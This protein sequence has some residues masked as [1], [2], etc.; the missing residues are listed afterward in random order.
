[1]IIWGSLLI[2][3][4]L[5]LIALYFFHKRI[6]WWEIIL[7]IGI[8][9]GIIL[10]IQAWY[11][12]SA[13]Q[14]PEYWGAYVEAVRYYEP[15]HEY[16]HQTC[17]ETYVCGSDS[18]GNPEY[19]TRTYDCSYHDFHPEY[20]VAI[21]NYGDEQTISKSE[22]DRLV[23]QFAIP[24]LNFV[25]LG[26][27]RWNDIDHCG[28][29]YDGD[30]Y[31]GN[32]NGD[33]NR[34]QPL[35]LKRDYTNKVIHSRTVFN[36]PVVSDTLPFLFSKLPTVPDQSRSFFGGGTIEHGFQWSAD[37]IRG[38]KVPNFDR[39]NHQLMK[40]NG[41]Y[42]RSHE[43]RMQIILYHNAPP[44]YGETLEWYWQGGNMN[45]FN[46]IVSVSDSNTIQWARVI[47]WTENQELK[48]K[49]RNFVST[50][51]PFNLPKI[52]QYMGDEVYK[53]WKRKDFKTDFAYL[54]ID[55]PTWLSIL[56]YSLVFTFSGGLA[57]FAVANPFV[58]SGSFFGQEDDSSAWGETLP[59]KIRRYARE[60]KKKS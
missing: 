58:N 40:L 51:K 14:E 10:G 21:D 32:F 12:V 56:I 45:E 26:H 53:L 7:I 59:K 2:P 24:R 44:L 11:R 4:I 31:Q 28:S 43:V 5:S 22:F 49:V 50:Q 25:E 30:A 16:V 60:S 33:L 57:L 36:Y 41:L 34:L 29:D 42:G 1:M 39:A 8:S 46:L 38:H 9:A 23:K 48:I 47:S 17:T 6:V 55:L 35:T 3:I 18:K 20:W 27:E 15:W 19:C 13:A 52:V 54:D 37:A